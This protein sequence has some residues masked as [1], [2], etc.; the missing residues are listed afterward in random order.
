MNTYLDNYAIYSSGNEAP[1]IYHKWAGICTLSNLISRKVWVEQ[2]FF[3]VYPNLYVIFVGNPG[4]GK[5]TAMK[6]ARDLIRVTDPDYTP[7]VPSSITRESLT[8]DLGDSGNKYLKSYELHGKQV[9]YTP[10][11]IF[12]NEIVTLLGSN[13]IGMI[14]FFTDIWD[15]DVFEVNTKNAGKDSIPKP[16]VNICGCMTP[17]ITNNLLKENI[18]S[19]GFARRCIFVH[20]S[21]RGEPVPIP[22]ITPEQ[23][24]ARNACL[25]WGK[26]LT[27]VVG[28]FSWDPEAKQLF[29]DWYKQNHE[30]VH[31]NTDVWL[32]GYYTSKN[33]LVLKVAILLALS[34]S[35]ELTLKPNHI[36]DS[37]DLLAETELDMHRVFAGTGRNSEAN[38][39]MRVLAM[40]DSAPDGTVREK[41]VFS[42]LFDNGTYDEITR[43]INHLI[44]VDKVVRVTIGNGVSCLRKHSGD[45]EPVRKPEGS[46]GLRPTG[47]GQELEG[48]IVL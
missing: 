9:P 42:V 31:T 44:N 21:R 32:N 16:A 47:L 43:A 38:L 4:N 39:A 18:I 1:P 22:V 23:L 33:A 7:I 19:G 12:A 41:K 37:L 6:I 29:V 36:Q 40:L 30:F 10:A 11:N 17:E 15:E 24:E 2:G 14:E 28:E 5:S 46:S 27:E 26:K 3:T 34:E 20:A 48:S 8:K 35:L 25:S 13:P 45:Q